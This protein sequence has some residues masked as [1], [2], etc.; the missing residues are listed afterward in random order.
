M[1]WYTAGLWNLEEGEE[2]ILLGPSKETVGDVHVPI[3]AGFINR[4]PQSFSLLVWQ[5]CSA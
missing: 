1:C 3:G 4:Y 5:D 2:E